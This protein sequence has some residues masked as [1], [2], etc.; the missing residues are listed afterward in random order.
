MI[1]NKEKKG[2]EK[3]RIKERK[4]RGKQKKQEVKKR[5]EH[6]AYTQ[7]KRQQLHFVI[8]IFRELS[9]SRKLR[10]E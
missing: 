5:T 1:R 6:A 9:R 3:K 7:T 10:N 4:A 2:K 8:S